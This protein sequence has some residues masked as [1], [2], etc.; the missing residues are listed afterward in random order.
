MNTNSGSEIKEKAD[1][2]WAKMYRLLGDAGV[3]D[4]NMFTGRH[5]VSWQA[6]AEAHD[7]RYLEHLCKKQ[8]IEEFCHTVGKR[9]AFKVTEDV[10]GREWKLLGFV[11]SER[12]L[13]DLLYAAY[14]LGMDDRLS[15]MAIGGIIAE[16]AALQNAMIETATISL[17]D[18]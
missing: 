10:Q 15:T 18:E 4:N 7:Q 17:E 13:L 14:R 6:L 3:T 8:M 2:L 9:F 12:E 11:F 1:L 16:R 5:K